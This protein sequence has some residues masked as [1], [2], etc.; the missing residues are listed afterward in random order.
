M[1][2]QI[3]LYKIDQQFKGLML[4]FLV[5]FHININFYY[6]FKDTI[7]KIWNL[8]IYLVWMMKIK[9]DLFK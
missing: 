8:E 2:T 3:Q 4:Q 7:H 9:S 1:F 6:M 5:T